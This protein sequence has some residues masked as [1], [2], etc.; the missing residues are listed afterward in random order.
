MVVLLCDY[1]G[2]IHLSSTLPS[3]LTLALTLETNLNVNA[4]SIQKYLNIIQC[5]NYTTPFEVVKIAFRVRS[6]K[7]N[8]IPFC[9]LNIHVI[10]MQWA[11]VLLPKRTKFHNINVK[12]WNCVQYIGN[13]FTPYYM[14]LI[15]Q[16]V[17]SVY[18]L[19]GV[20]MCCNVHACL[21]HQSI[22]R[23]SRNQRRRKVIRSL[24]P[25][26][27]RRFL[28][29]LTK[30]YPVPTPAFRAGAPVDIALV[31]VERGLAK[32]CLRCVLW[33]HAMDGFPAIDTLHTQ[34]AHLSR[35]AILRRHIFIVH[36]RST[37]SSYS[38]RYGLVSVETFT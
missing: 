34:A 3:S 28:L 19:Y 13:R 7:P 25:P 26:W 15:I 17:K 2:V 16:M 37:S 11:L 22:S 29:L 32:L 24:F 30:N 18:T 36:R 21:A 1:I 27:A 35:A 20:I 14:R 5:Q 10:W 23:C 9:S 8:S 31:L 38:Y 6:I 12:I 33:M 4:I